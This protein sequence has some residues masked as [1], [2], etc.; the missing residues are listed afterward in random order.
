MGGWMDGRKTRE[1]SAQAVIGDVAEVNGQ[2]DN[3]EQPVARYLQNALVGI[4]L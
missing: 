3:V 4:G 1:I 2:R